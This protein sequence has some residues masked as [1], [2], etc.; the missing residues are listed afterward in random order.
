MVDHIAKAKDAATVIL[1]N[2]NCEFL[3]MERS[4]QSVFLPNVSVFPGGGLDNADMDKSLLDFAPGFN[5]D[6]KIAGLYFAAIRELF[7]EA[8]VLFSCLE[9]GTILDLE[10]ASIRS[11][12]I[13]YRDMIHENKMT[14]SV[15]AEKENLIYI[16]EALTPFSRWITPKAMKT[17]YDTRFFIAV[18]P[19]RQ[20]VSTDDNELINYTWIKA[21]DA[22][23]LNENARIKLLPPTLFILDELKTFSKVDEIIDYAVNKD[24]PVIMP[25][26]FSANGTAGVRFPFAPDYSDT[27]YK[28]PPVSGIPSRALIT[29]NGWQ[30]F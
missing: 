25:E 28:L 17:R 11:R 13:E 8:F 9:E 4:P 27:D 24:K 26:A 16:P 2:K 19:D 1:I 3:L 18:I 30:L 22:I 5:D 15:L 7:E 10:N 14:L 12:F 23:T 20:Q 29:D 21:A 6:E